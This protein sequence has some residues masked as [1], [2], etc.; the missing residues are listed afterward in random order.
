ML[1]SDDLLDAMDTVKVIAFMEVEPLTDKFEQIALTKPQAKAMRDAL[2]EILTGFKPGTKDDEGFS[3]DLNDEVQVQLP[4][5]R[6]Y[7]E[8]NFFDQNPSVDS[9]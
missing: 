6:D 4:N 2:Y 7:Y 3:V 5:V 8:Q 1:N 9:D